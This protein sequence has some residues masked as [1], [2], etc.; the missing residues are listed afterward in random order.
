M[1]CEPK[2]KHLTR[3]NYHQGF[4][5]DEELMAGVGAVTTPAESGAPGQFFA[6]VLQHTTG[7]YLGYD[8]LP[9][10]D[11]AL[12]AINRIER[13]WTYESLGGCDGTRC[14]EGKC[15]GG[16]C[17]LYNGAVPG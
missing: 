16:A 17:K 2:G 4:L 5:V 7:E 9:D 13:E 3:E 12:A 1:S 8:T 10:L 11:S 15:K 6:Y 14:A